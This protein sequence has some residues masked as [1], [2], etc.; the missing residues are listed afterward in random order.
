SEMSDA[1]VSAIYRHFEIDS[2]RVL[3]DLTRSLDRM[4]SGNSRNPA[5]SPRIVRLLSEAWS[6]GS[7]EYSATQIRSAFL[8]TALLTSDTLSSFATNSCPELKRISVE[9]L[10]S[11]LLSICGNS[12]EDMSGF[13]KQEHGEAGEQPEAPAG[14]SRAAK[15]SLDQFT[16]NLTQAALD[17]KIDPVL[18]RDFEVRQI[19]DILTRRRQNN[20]ILTGEAGVGKT[21]VVEGFARRV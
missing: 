20:P 5:I 13:I 10:R 2:A 16:I 9:T 12:V 19:I 15:S 14:P 7:V 21:A 3:R 1:D 8:L 18:G 11:E 6:L 17:G 4:R